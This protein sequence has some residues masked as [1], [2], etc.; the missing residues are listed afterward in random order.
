MGVGAGEQYIDADCTQEMGSGT[1][2]GV[3]ERKQYRLGSH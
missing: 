2:V 3:G 1:G